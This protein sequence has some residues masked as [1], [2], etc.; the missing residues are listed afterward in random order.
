MKEFAPSASPDDPV[1]DDGA[2]VR[3]QMVF[4]GMKKK[5]RRFHFVQVPNAT[6]G[7]KCESL[8]QLLGSEA[9]SN[10]PH[11]DRWPAVYLGATAGFTR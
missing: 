4:V 11:T 3:Q 5:L 2:A 6:I 9:K 8:N 7:K 1:P 10:L